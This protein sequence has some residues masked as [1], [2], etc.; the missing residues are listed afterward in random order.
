[1]KQKIISFLK[2]AVKFIVIITIALNLISL[3]KSRDIRKEDLVLKDINLISGTNY[4]IKN[5]EPVLIHFWATWCP[6]CKIENPSIQK[7]SK[8]HQVITVA[9]ESGDDNVIKRFMKENNL[10]FKT[11]NDPY[12]TLAEQFNI[13]GYPTTLIYDKKGKLVFSEVGYTSTLGLK[14]RL[15][16][17]SL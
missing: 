3:Y 15:F 17:A 6:V 1:M 11:A 5:T 2:E 14:L 7:L 8:D 12:R 16:W 13:K 9:V 4:Q 10:S